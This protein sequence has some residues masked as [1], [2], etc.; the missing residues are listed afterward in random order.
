MIVRGD[1]VIAADSAPDPSNMRDEPKPAFSDARDSLVPPD[2]EDWICRYL[3]SGTRVYGTVDCLP[4]RFCV[5]TYFWHV[6]WL[7]IIPIESWL[8]VFDDDFPNL[9]NVPLKLNL[10][11]VLAGWLRPSK[12]I[13]TAVLAILS[14]HAVA[15]QEFGFA[16]L[17]FIIA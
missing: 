1:R 17:A 10:R 7:P 8:F 12:W 4:N 2:E 3:I 6:F 5:G 16:L 11:S 13:V 9:R 14:V 15:E